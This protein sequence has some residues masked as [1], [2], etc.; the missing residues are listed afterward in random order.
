MSNS[1]EQHR[2]DLE[3]LADSDLPVASVA[4]ALLEEVEQT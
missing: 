1:I 2:D 4:E 3:A